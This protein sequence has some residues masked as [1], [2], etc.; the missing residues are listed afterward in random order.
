MSGQPSTTKR[1]EILQVREDFNPDWY[2][3]SNPPP[4]YCREDGIP[5]CAFRY[6]RS[7]S[8]L[9]EYATR[10]NLMAERGG[11]AR[12]TE[13]AI[14]HIM[15]ALGQTTRLKRVGKTYEHTAAEKSPG[16]SR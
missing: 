11:F 1:R 10:H 3:V 12:G 4:L 13:R 9:D 15:Q 16:D 5:P 14:V 8:W 6:V 2:T 7:L